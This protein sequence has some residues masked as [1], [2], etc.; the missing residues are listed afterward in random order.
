MSLLLAVDVLCTRTDEMRYVAYII[1]VYTTQEG[2]KVSHV[3]HGR[4]EDLRDTGRYM[5][6]RAIRCTENAHMRWFIV[7]LKHTGYLLCFSI[8][9]DECAEESIIVVWRS[10]KS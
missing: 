5:H 3:V 6:P 8:R 2:G 7:V 9:S 4:V 1:E 10:S